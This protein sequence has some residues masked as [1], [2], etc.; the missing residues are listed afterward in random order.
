MRDEDGV[1]GG[2]EMDVPDGYNHSLL[3]CYNNMRVGVSERVVG[4]G[5]AVAVVVDAD[6]SQLYVAPVGVAVA[7][8]SILKHIVGIDKAGDYK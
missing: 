7:D 6:R 4:D 8:G 5:S 2:E 3:R 1:D